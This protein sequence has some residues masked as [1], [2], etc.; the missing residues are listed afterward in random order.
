MENI[1]VPFDFSVSSSWGFYYA[2]ELA[3][4]IDAEIIVV[5]IYSPSTE[6]T[7]SLEKLQTNAP[8]RKIEIL[9]HLKA[10]TQYPIT[11][12]AKAV[13]ISY[14]IG[15]GE[16]EAIS[17]YA[18]RKNV[19]LIVMGTDGSD[20]GS[21]KILGSNTNKVIEKAH[22][23]VL[24]IPTGTTF[25]LVQNIAYATNFDSKD[26][27][28]ITQLGKVAKAT[29]ST[30]QC[31]HVDL[32][33]EGAETDKRAA[34]EAEVKTSLEGLPIV[35]NT[36]SAHNVEDGLEIFCRVYNIDMLAMLTHNRSTWDKLFGEHSLTK[37][38]AMRNKLPLF[39][40][41]G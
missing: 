20:K 1:L 4:T 37:S 17:A 8:K 33:S 32:F 23:P 38:M 39:A 18:K 27:E 3:A 12:D 19:D 7:Y 16:K 5:N 36:W 40:F 29:N 14:D 25:K 11:V 34:F 13:K 41:H 26:I 28:S 2:C 22:C 21:N 35:F 31:I 30:L 6:A 10:A 24:A 9:A 15:Y